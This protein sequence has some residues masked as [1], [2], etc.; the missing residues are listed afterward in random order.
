MARNR[1][2]RKARRP[3]R[4]AR[5]Y[6]RFNPDETLLLD[7][8]VEDVQVRK[9]RGER[10][11]GEAVLPQPVNPGQEEC[12][13]EKVSAILIPVN[14]SLVA[15][16]R[17]E[18]AS[19]KAAYK[20]GQLS[21]EEMGRLLVL[22]SAFAKM[23]RYTPSNWEKKGGPP[24]GELGGKSRKAFL[25]ACGP[26]ADE[27]TPVF[28]VQV[29][30][31]QQ[32]VGRLTGFYEDFDN[33]FGW[34][35][36]VMGLT[37]ADARKDRFGVQLL[38]PEDYLQETSVGGAKEEVPTFFSSDF[39]DQLRSRLIESVATAVKMKE[40]GRSPGDALESAARNVYK[41]A[42]KLVTGGRRPRTQAE[43]ELVTARVQGLVDTC[44]LRLGP[45][46]APPCYFPKSWTDRQMEVVP[47]VRRRAV[48]NLVS[49]VLLAM[50]AADPKT[51][52]FSGPPYADVMR[53]RAK[54]I[55]D[56]INSPEQF[57]KWVESTNAPPEAKAITAYNHTIVRRGLTS[58]SQLVAFK[59][60]G[61]GKRFTADNPEQVIAQLLDVPE[62]EHSETENLFVVWSREP[63][64]IIVP[65]LPGVPEEALIQGELSVPDRKGNLLEGA[66]EGQFSASTMT[67]LA[68]SVKPG[69]TRR[70]R[71]G[72]DT[73]VYVVTCKSVEDR[74]AEFVAAPLSEQLLE[75]LST[76]QSG[77]AL[78]D[79]VFAEMS[80][81]QSIQA[82]AT[83]GARDYGKF[84]RQI[85][86]KMEYLRRPP[87]FLTFPS[88]RIEDRQRISPALRLEM[89]PDPRASDAEM[90]T[91]TVPLVATVQTFP[92]LREA[93]EAPNTRSEEIVR[94]MLQRAG[95]LKID[96]NKTVSPF[97]PSLV[98]YAAA[99][100][101][102]I[103]GA[104]RGISLGKADDPR[105]LYFFTSRSEV[106]EKPN[107]SSRLVPLQLTDHHRALLH[108]AFGADVTFLPN[109]KIDFEP[110]GNVTL[111]GQLSVT[112]MADPDFFRR[113]PGVLRLME[114]LRERAKK[115]AQ[116][117]PDEGLEVGQKQAYAKREAPNYEESEQ[118]YRQAVAQ[119]LGYLFN[120]PP[121]NRELSARRSRADLTGSF[122]RQAVRGPGGE[123]MAKASQ[124]ANRWAVPAS[125]RSAPTGW[126]ANLVGLMRDSDKLYAPD[127]MDIVSEA[128][129]VDEMLLAAAFEAYKVED[130]EGSPVADQIK[131]LEKLK[132]K[133]EKSP[134][135]TLD[136]EELEFVPAP[137]V[138]G[139]RDQ[140]GG[141]G[142]EEAP[143]DEFIARLN[144]EDDAYTQYLREQFSGEKDSTP[145]PE[146][147]T[148]DFRGVRGAF[149]QRLQK[150]DDLKPDAFASR[151]GTY[152]KFVQHSRRRDVG[153]F[154]L[155]DFNEK[156]ADQA[157]LSVPETK[158]II[159]RVSDAYGRR[160]KTTIPASSAMC[161]VNRVKKLV[162]Y[163][164]P[165]PMMLAGPPGF[166]RKKALVWVSPEG[167]VSGRI[168]VYRRN[169]HLDCD[170]P[171]GAGSARS[172]GQAIALGLQDV[173]LWLGQR[174]SRLRDTFVYVGR[175]GDGKLNLAWKP[176]QELTFESML[177]ML[178]QDGGSIVVEEYDAEADLARYRSAEVGAVG[179][180]AVEVPSAPQPAR[181][182]E[183]PSEMPPEKGEEEEEEGEE[184]IG[185]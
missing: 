74:A 112:P 77:P 30:N 3:R 21:P 123:L 28:L 47:S 173:L 136:R 56:K 50:Y 155:T 82:P 132:A 115:K 96:P 76:V 85:A 23:P 8:P 102:P 160:F 52:G 159:Q 144:P 133:V 103:K 140:E 25:S 92:N 54:A 38:L 40:L 119:Y 105:T 31:A 177:Q 55:A 148:L 95:E 122:V 59:F 170:I 146:G 150:K 131:A 121:Y 106:P 185:F 60:V 36:L 157:G 49:R 32:N 120:D 156:L 51:S 127:S 168:M 182:V 113:H 172:L 158:R 81:V 46:L 13:P 7:A 22:A 80:L 126:E 135:Q 138:V 167:A 97:L 19:V 171:F 154:N 100:K 72:D 12:K 87:R 125:K 53:A 41:R 149:P 75:V 110:R 90:L 34:P 69:Q 137:R 107:A 181:D 4:N 91:D 134:I 66:Q 169:T 44:L 18:A 101:K 83:V 98:L 128:Y 145:V 35:Y 116:S 45:L 17:E 178:D 1:M 161:A 143:E 33:P 124:S 27:D 179:P 5:R 6:A 26:K 118:L 68:K 130:A 139:F 71:F 153:D 176:G 151:I 94:G 162:G 99:F 10:K 57:I 109:G 16:A 64:V 48:L 15:W 89:F 88:A 37:A 67:T 175:V 84:I 73:T 166:E 164:L 78:V 86:G 184:E 163:R 111:D 39:F 24:R 165:G 141:F 180:I 63:D 2:P 9:G 152:G 61:S 147:A 62:A 58:Y 142:F 114:K 70:V 14:E 42:G 29:S 174:D 104:P 93:I 11:S 43:T 183:F 108:N 79:E 20:A 129:N 117:N 65:E